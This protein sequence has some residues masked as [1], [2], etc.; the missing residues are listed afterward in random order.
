MSGIHNLTYGKLP[1]FLTAWKIMMDGNE[2]LLLGI[3]IQ[4]PWQL[5]SQQLNTEKNPHEGTVNLNK[6]GVICFA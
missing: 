5:V 2:I 1:H 3:G 6:S 4:S